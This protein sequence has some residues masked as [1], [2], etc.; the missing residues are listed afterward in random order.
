MDKRS[1][2]NLRAAAGSAAHLQHRRHGYNERAGQTRVF[3]K[4]IDLFTNVRASRYFPVGGAASHYVVETDPIWLLHRCWAEVRSKPSFI[5]P[6]LRLAGRKLA[7][8]SS[9]N[10]PQKSTDGLTAAHLHIW[11]MLRTQNLFFKFCSISAF[12]CMLTKTSK[13]VKKTI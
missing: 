8:T 5:H 7:S 11:T 3:P 2:S 6:L 12:K 4:A 1:R 9:A 13:R 10:Q